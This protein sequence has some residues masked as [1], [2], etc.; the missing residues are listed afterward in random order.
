MDL[1]QSKDPTYLQCNIWYIFVHSHILQTSASGSQTRHGKKGLQVDQEL[2]KHIILR[3]KVANSTFIPKIMWQV[4]KS[5]V[6]SILKD[7]HS[8][9][10]H[11]AQKHNTEK[12]LLFPYRFGVFNL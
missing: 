3:T 1:A 9:T 7:I 4:I 2:I 12:Q 11:L 6:V 5:E 8:D 10:I